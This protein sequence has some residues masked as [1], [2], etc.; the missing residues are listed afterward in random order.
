MSAEI[1][2]LNGP[3]AFSLWPAHEVN[4]VYMICSMCDCNLARLTPA[5]DVY[6]FRG[7]CYFMA[8]GCDPPAPAHKAEAGTFQHDLLSVTMLISCQT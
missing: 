7:L 5:A 3:Q 1:P 6:Q 4:S 2:S 8:A